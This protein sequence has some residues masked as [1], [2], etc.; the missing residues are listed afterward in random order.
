MAIEKRRDSIIAPTGT[1]SGIA[2][3]AAVAPMATLALATLL[4]GGVFFWALVM[5]IAAVVIY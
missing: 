1:T 2:I 4:P 3:G 5:I